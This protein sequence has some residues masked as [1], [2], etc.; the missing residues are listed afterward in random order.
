[1][2]ALPNFVDGLGQLLEDGEMRERL[3]EAGRDWARTYHTRTRFLEEFI[4]LAGRVRS[5]RS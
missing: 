1:M 2:A 5:P 3:G 4:S